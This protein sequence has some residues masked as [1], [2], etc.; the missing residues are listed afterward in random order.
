MLL[1]FLW[2]VVFVQEI[3]RVFEYYQEH[4]AI[5]KSP[6]LKKRVQY[7]YVRKFW[8]QR[9]ATTPATTANN[10]DA[11]AWRV[12]AELALLLVAAGAPEDV[13]DPDAAPVDEPVAAGAEVFPSAICW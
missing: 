6:A 10:P 4:N 12:F 9:R 1:S 11:P 3:Y 8:H 5:F 13:G 2:T 7:I